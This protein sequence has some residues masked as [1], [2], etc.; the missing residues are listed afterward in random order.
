MNT[1]V[2]HVITGFESLSR[3]L[4]QMTLTVN[5]MKNWFFTKKNNAR[6]TYMKDIVKLEEETGQ[7]MK[8][9]E[10]HLMSMNPTE[11]K[12]ETQRH[13]LC[14]QLSKGTRT[15]VTVQFST[16]TITKD[17]TAQNQEDCE[18]SEGLQPN[19]PANKHKT[20]L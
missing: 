6:N 5:G 13:L 10:D 8:S 18:Q 20:K 4:I 3:R 15:V 9:M 17:K 12:K 11:K 1:L 16:K 19:S 2:L 14:E 7:R